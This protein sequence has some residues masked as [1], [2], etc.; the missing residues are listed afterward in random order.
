MLLPVIAVYF[1]LYFVV[2]RFFIKKLD[3]KTPGR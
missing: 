3:L 1:L 2:F